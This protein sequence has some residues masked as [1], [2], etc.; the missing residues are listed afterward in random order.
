[1]I[2]VSA[3]KKKNGE[4]NPQSAIMLSRSDPLGTPSLDLHHDQPIPQ[5]FPPPKLHVPPPGSQAPSS[6]KNGRSRIHPVAKLQFASA[7]QATYE[8]L[9]NEMHNDKH[10]FQNLSLLFTCRK[11]IQGEREIKLLTEICRELHQTPSSATTCNRREDRPISTPWCRRL[12]SVQYTPISATEQQLLILRHPHAG[13]PP[14][15]TPPLF[16]AQSSTEIGT[17]G[18]TMVS[19]FSLSFDQF[20]IW[21]NICNI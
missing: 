13:P 10:Y 20:P 3:E 4:A 18:S 14:P 17:V 6:G 15:S 8:Q 1:M 5:P 12:E 21:G 2:F 19:S 9:V 11:K 7:T 16:P